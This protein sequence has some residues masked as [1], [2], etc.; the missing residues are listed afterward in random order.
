[1]FHRIACVGW[2]LLW[3]GRGEVRWWG[4]DDWLW[5]AELTIVRKP[6]QVQGLQSA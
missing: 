3:E 2:E 5:A 6:G 1:M 4:I